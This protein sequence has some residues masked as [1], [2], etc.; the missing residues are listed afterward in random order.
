MSDAS[1]RINVPTGGLSSTIPVTRA[2]NI[3]PRNWAAVLF[4]R[5]TGQRFEDSSGEGDGTDNEDS[6]HHN[7]AFNRPLPR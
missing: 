2:S 1:S 3:N 4:W 6:D 7:V 5:I